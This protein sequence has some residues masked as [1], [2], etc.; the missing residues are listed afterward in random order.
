MTKSTI[1]QM[2]EVS[3]ILPRKVAIVMITRN[4][5]EHIKSAI[6]SIISNTR[7]PHKLIIIEAESTD[8]TANICNQYAT[9]Y[10]NIEV[11]HIKNIGPLKAINYGL[12]VVKPYDVYL[13]HDDVIHPQL[14]RKDWL[15]EF[16]ASAYK[17]NSAGATALNGFGVSG[18]D[19]IDNFQWIGTWSWYIRR[20]TIDKIGYFDENFGNGMGDDIDYSYRIFKAGLKMHV[21]EVYVEHH[22]MTGR[23]GSDV[24]EEAEKIK[25]KNALYFRSKHKLGEFNDKEK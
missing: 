17:E 6:N 9:V 18:P 3:S 10:P 7:Y 24:T 11:H 1:Q 8:G 15:T 19:Y 22:R 21:A 5:K 25:K 23:S 20:R 4:S 16:V 14:Y 2:E 13:T 12:E